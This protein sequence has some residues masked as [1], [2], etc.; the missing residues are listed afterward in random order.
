VVEG[1]AKAV[2]K[3]CTSLMG[4][5]LTISENFFFH[6]STVYLRYFSL[7]PQFREEVADF[8]LK[9]SILAVFTQFKKTIKLLNVE[10]LAVYAVISLNKNSTLTCFK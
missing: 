4:Q 5:Y 9:F 10:F 7:T 3:C 6:I 8:G 1:I 2:S